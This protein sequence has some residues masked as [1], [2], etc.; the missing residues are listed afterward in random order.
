MNVRLRSY[1]DVTEWS[2]KRVARITDGDWFSSN[3]TQIYYVVQCGIS[4]GRLVVD[5]DGG[6]NSILPVRDI[7][8]LPDPPDTV[9]HSVVEVEVWVAG[10]GK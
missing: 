6:A 10:G 3:I 4:A 1:V 8:V 2:C 7:L 5:S 9:D